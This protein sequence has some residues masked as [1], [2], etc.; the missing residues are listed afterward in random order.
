MG[1][2]C[3]WLLPALCLI[4]S[5]LFCLLFLILFF[6]FFQRNKSCSPHPGHSRLL[7]TMPAPQGHEGGLGR[8]KNLVL[9]QSFSE[10]SARTS[11]FRNRSQAHD[12]RR[13]AVRNMVRVGIPDRVAMMIS[14]HKTR[15]VFERYNIV[16]KG[17]KSAVDSFLFFQPKLLFV[18]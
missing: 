7:T 8:T 14:G 13:T 3:L 18:S 12:F 1:Q 4:S 9:E 10:R 5:S 2:A 16:K 15:S 17:V 11:L 6:S